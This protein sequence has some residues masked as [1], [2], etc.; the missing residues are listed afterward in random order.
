M[1][2]SL[3]SWLQWARHQQGEESEQGIDGLRRHRA[4]K[5]Q[6]SI[7]S[8]ELRCMWVQGWFTWNVC[9]QPLDMCLEPTEFA[10]DDY[11]YWGLSGKK[12]PFFFQSCVHLSDVFWL[13]NPS[14]VRTAMRLRTSSGTKGQSGEAT[15]AWHSEW[16]PAS[17]LRHP[18]HPVATSGRVMTVFTCIQCWQV[19]LF[20]IM[21]PFLNKLFVFACNSQNKTAHYSIFHTHISVSSMRAICK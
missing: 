2:P 15:A 20:L 8:G 6:R 3:A 10:T 5:R 9:A 18:F 17:G 14:K 4:I 7:K 19:V 13:Q 11:V 12:T 16:L 1:K 21:I